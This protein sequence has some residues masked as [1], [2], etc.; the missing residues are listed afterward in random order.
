MR[1]VKVSSSGGADLS[2]LFLRQTSGR[3]GIW[4]DCQ[5]IVNQP[6]ER[7]DWWV[8][9]HGS[10]LDRSE[11][12]YC[13]PS[14]IVYISMEPAEI[15]T[16]PSFLNQ[17]SKLVL[18]DRSISHSAIQY[19]NGLTWWVGMNVRHERGHHF[20]PQFTYD[21][22][23][24]MAMSLPLKQ[25]RIS[26]ICSRNQSLPGHHK[27]LAFLDKLQRHPISE[28]IDFFGGG[29]RPILDKW[30]AIARYK[31]HLV[32][33]NSV[34]PDYWSEKLG[35]AYLGF[36]LP[37]YYGCPNI[38]KYFSEKSLI[39]VDIDDFEGTVGVLEG[40]MRDDPFE[41]CLSDVVAARDQVI[42]QYNIFQLMADIC[43]APASRYARCRVKPASHFARSWPRRLARKVIHRL[44]GIQSE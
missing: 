38:D 10:A 34:V 43:N 21:Y 4:G 6:V 23:S 5:F 25:Q 13:D 1:V 36:S 8:V 7:C 33:E 29:H 26:V 20:S 9:C 18:C 40:L 16:P 35:D 42:N 28:Y 12:T 15:R 14:H 39:C 37:I 3:K 30:D 31:Y 11:S 41:G 17:F 24:L 27:R 32:L 19:A 2:G 44:R 22:D